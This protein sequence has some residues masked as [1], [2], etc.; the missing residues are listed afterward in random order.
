MFLDR[1]VSII[2]QGA[3][4]GFLLFYYLLLTGRYSHGIQNR[5]TV[6]ELIAQQFP[7]HLTEDRA[8]WK[9]HEFWPD[10]HWARATQQRPRL[11]LICNPFFDP[12][13]YHSNLELTCDSVKILLYTSLELQARL[14]W[15]KQAWWFT[16]VSRQRYQ[17][18]TD[19]A[20]MRWILNQ[21]DIDPNVHQIKSTY[22]PDIVIRLE[23]FV[24]DPGCLGLT[25]NQEQLDFVTYWT[26]LQSK[27]TQRLLRYTID[28]KGCG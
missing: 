22:H 17:R 11:Y 25:P 23:D 4:G 10:N 14:A 12:G 19:R 15:E 7:Q 2:Y 27:K 28:E 16:P 9:H 8:K 3:S 20:Y 24:S 6:S 5:L 21:G 13:L 18:G 26:S 1:D